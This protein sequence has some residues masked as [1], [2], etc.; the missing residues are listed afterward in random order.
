MRCGAFICPAELVYQYSIR[1]FSW[2]ECTQETL[3][4]VHPCWHS[5]SYP[6]LCRIIPREG[7]YHHSWPH[8]YLPSNLTVVSSLEKVAIQSLISW[9]TTEEKH[10]RV[11]PPRSFFCTANVVRSTIFTQ[12]IVEYRWTTRFNGDLTRGKQDSILS[13]HCGNRCHFMYIRTMGL[14]GNVLHDA[15]HIIMWW[16]NA[17]QC[18]RDAVR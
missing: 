17:V 4:K 6:M 9:T 1:V 3:G 8:V 18:E 7:C 10:P 2:V 16:T 12:C 15:V 11:K 5:K 14:A 13:D